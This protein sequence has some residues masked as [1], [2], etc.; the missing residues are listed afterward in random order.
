M[1]IVCAV[2]V[3][4]AMGMG[5]H[6]WQAQTLTFTHSL[7]NHWIDT[8]TCTRLH[9]HDCPCVV[10]SH[11][12]KTQ[13]DNKE[14]KSM[15]VNKHF[16]STPVYAVQLATLI[17]VYTYYLDKQRANKN[18][19]NVQHRDITTRWPDGGYLIARSEYVPGLPVELAAALEGRLPMK[20]SFP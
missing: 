16:S 10:F 6:K 5:I 11:H 8:H 20:D 3:H 2:N 4:P 14:S 1:H 13:I 15:T 17:S 18:Y 19:S 7:S 12:L 9:R